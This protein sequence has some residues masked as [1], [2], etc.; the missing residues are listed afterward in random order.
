[1]P[2]PASCRECGVALPAGARFCPSCAA[3]IESPPG[4]AERKLATVLFADLVGST[5]LAGSRDPEHTRA[6]LDRFYDAMA[7]EIGAAGGTIEKYAG[8]AVMAVFGVPA[9]YEDHAERALGAA[10]AMRARLAELFG[11]ALQLRLGVNTGEVVVGRPR[12]GSSFASGDAVNVAARLEQ[13]AEPGE[14][15]VGERTATAVGRAFEFD[16]PRSIAAKGKPDG[17]ACRRLLRAR[18]SGFRR[19]R[20]TFVGRT[21][22]L[23][24]LHAIYDRVCD[25][26]QPGFAA[27]VGD[28]G[29]GKTRIVRELLDDLTRVKPP[30]PL[31]L[32][33]RC[34]SYGRGNTYWPLAEVLRER[35]GVGVNDAPG[36]V[37]D[38]LR[39]REILALTFG[40]DVAGDVHPRVARSRLYEA[41]RELVEEIAGEC[42]L[43]LVAEDLHWAE[44]PLL[45]LLEHLVSVV[46]EPFLV[47]GTSRAELPGRSRPLDAVLRLAPLSRQDA[48]QI[49]DELAIP[50][51]L[52]DL[53]VERAEGNPFFLE[54]F[55]AML[56]D[57]GHFDSE[58]GLPADF[59]LP[60]SI[61][62]V[63]AA[64]IDLLSSSE[65]AALQAASV[66]GRQFGATAVGVLLDGIEP[67]LDALEERD[68]VRQR[69]V[70]SLG[71]EREYIFKHGLTRDVA[72]STLTRA[73]RARL[74]AAF[75]R[76]LEREG[77]GSD[78]HAA[79]LGHHYAQAAAPEFVALAWPDE[80]AQREVVRGKAVT[81]LRRAAELAAARYAIAEALTLLDRALLL[82]HD[83]EDKIEILRQKGRAHV[84]RYDVGGFR[85]SIEQALALRPARS[86]AA[87]LYAQ[88]AYYGIGR[89]YM[90]KQPPP[91]ELGEKWLAKAL[92]LAEPG[93]EARGH[94][95]LSQALSAP[96]TGADAA[97][98]AYRLGEALGHPSLVAY[99]CEAQALG[100]TQAGRYE[101]AC[102]WAARALEATRSLSDPGVIGY[103]YWNAGFVFLRGGRIA[104]VR[105][106]AER[107]DR[108]ASSL[109]P[110]EEVHAVA[111]HAVLE[112]VLGNWD[113]LAELTMRAESA[114]VANDDFPCQFNWRTLL[115]CALGFVQLGN[116]RD[117]ARRLEDAARA[118]A[119]VA[120]PVEREPALLRLALASGDL[121]AARRIVRALPA[122]GDAFGVDAPAARLDA[123]VALGEA[124]RVEEEAAQFFDRPSYTR[125]FALRALGIAR[126]D[127]SLVEQAVES[128]E[129]MGLAW[130]ADETR[131]QFAGVAKG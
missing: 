12:V 19:V 113:A 86:V 38:R 115:V 58:S 64:R 7:D 82:E 83:D 70:S 85:D 72:Y 45:D 33:G 35:L 78:E 71:A 100:A 112:S 16:E 22:E 36:T 8:D 98:E 69:A 88:L 65:K 121:D 127:G 14:V 42:P 44:E 73:R 94:A 81:W 122:T 51:A 75:A 37:L 97:E 10:L 80:P 95:L 32:S 1:M 63:L 123:L 46:R 2:A 9:A 60:D 27:I 99:A 55:V 24:R 102:G 54:E 105:P 50:A 68:L 96:D 23:E 21:Q 126:R 109:S 15:V 53:V 104:E 31:T 20:A 26:G 74:H 111:L 129:A 67:E 116:G 56:I 103:Q 34:L 125:P 110:H 131:A 49:V 57:H 92:A 114:T 47:L 62:S 48:E 40:L 18:A 89:P 28:A 120:G 107:Y 106:L 41:W 5:Q 39:G 117:E 91:R 118:R 29:V 17:V 93:T 128:F 84:L 25:S 76:W 3:P 87:H 6:L 124:D 79:L 130:R 61:Q 119:V 77:E 101:D 52:R 108:L 66:V 13:A 30:G 43:V 59:P 4:E 11:D 90:W